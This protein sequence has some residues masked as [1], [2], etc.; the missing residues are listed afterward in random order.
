M[1]RGGILWATEEIMEVLE[2]NPKYKVNYEF[3]LIEMNEWGEK[4]EL[5]LMV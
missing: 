1:A 4:E 3:I 2:Y 5:F